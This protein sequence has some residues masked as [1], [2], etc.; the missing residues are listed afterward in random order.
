[1]AGPGR[2]DGDDKFLGEPAAPPTEALRIRPAELDFMDKVAPLIPRTPRAV[3]RFVNIY[4]LYKAALSTP[5]LSSF[6]GSPE[7]PGNFRAVQVLLA[8]V[9]GIPDFAKAVV[10]ILDT[11]EE[12]S[13]KTLSDIPALLRGPTDPTWQ[14][15]LNALQAFAVGDNDLALDSLRQVSP[16][17]TRYSLHHMVSALPGDSTL[18]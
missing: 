12:S 10:E 11:L 18:G 14:T 16:L 5:G 17:V 4:R 8:L 1:M 15:T 3:K 9:I 7:H 13:P 6:L 2:G